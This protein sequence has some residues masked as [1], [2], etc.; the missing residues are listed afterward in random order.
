MFASL[1]YSHRLFEKA[2]FILL[3]SSVFCCESARSQ[4]NHS[5][6]GGTGP[7][8]ES[9][10]RARADAL[11]AQMTP[12]EKIGQMTQ[13]F[14]LGNPDAALEARIKNGEI[15]AGLFVIDPA[16]NNRIQRMAVEESRLHI[17]IL[18]GFDVIHGFKT[19]FPVPIAMAASWDREIVERAQTVAA[20][21]AYTTGIRWTFA[22]MVDIGRDPR[23]GRI[24]EGAGEDPFL[25]SAMA[26]AQVHGFQGDYL[27]APDHLVATVKHFA[28]YG[29]AEGGRDYDAAEIS[30]S[31][32]RNV[33]FPP[34]KNA[35]DA[36]AGVVMS[37]YMDLNGV[38]AS[39][40]R[41]LLHDVLR[42]EW[43]FRGFVVSDSDAVK[44]LKT[45]GFAV[46][47][48]DAALR[49]AKAG[50]NM[51][52]SLRG[53]A[54]SSSL[55]NLYADKRLSDAELDEAVRPILE[56]KIRLGLFENPYVD[57]AGMQANLQT[58]QN[59][60]LARIAAERSAVLLRNQGELLPLKDSYKKIAVIGSLADSK[61]DV[62]GPWA[63]ASDKKD[64][65]TVLE[66][67][68]QG[69]P[70][71]VS[72][73]YAGGVQVSR[74]FPLGHD[75]YRGTRPPVWTE[76]QAKQEYARAVSLA[77]DSDL[78]IV[79]LGE[80]QDMGGEE[81]SS[82]TLRLPGR[83]EE[84]LKDV[85]AT[86]KPVVLLLMSARPLDLRWAVA[87]VAAILDIWYPGT[88]GGTAVANL[89]FGRSVPGGK[90]PFTWVRDAGQV[91]T[92]YAHYS[93]HEP[94][95]QGARYWN[96]ES[97]PLFPFGFGLSYTSFQISDLSLSQSSLS[98]NDPLEVSVNVRNSGT[99]RG[100]EV[101]QI[102]IHQ[103]SGT[104]SRPVRELKGFKRI[105]LAPG[106]IQ[107]VRFTL[108]AQDRTYWS[109]AT[110][111][112]VQDTAG[113]DVWVGDDSA[114]T[115]H[116]AFSVTH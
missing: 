6:A 14:I 40:N 29:A 57:E 112:W 41:W 26:V 53:S 12:R 50:V 3:L 55:P 92:F 9:V 90:L 104:S 8:S 81:S 43:H 46:D 31:Q 82:S 116:G 84:L 70:S 110:R 109:A 51:E 63:F 17:P 83:Q 4:E 75:S 5:V 103:Q 35:I 100:D 80:N 25:G 108:T 59:Y 54:Y 88:Q 64:S 62:A 77:R 30:E 34:F 22:P 93:T 102:Y 20:K 28:G 15:G 106:E 13:I 101:V 99:T 96:E 11:L 33:Y 76:E 67:L 21:E 71:G 105:S 58:K 73:N 7:L 89:L 114:A 94:E 72:I 115:L 19:I 47:E 52:M 60:E 107:S 86:G 23:W 37:A 61:S 27:G 66:G 2:V 49:A 74:K 85:V 95:K 24:I 87:H 45:H 56:T 32:L 16:L 39:G 65:V 1:R 18:F 42:D 68:R 111:S 91:P 44:S 36:G 38:P 10:V 78:S 98:R 69:A 79:V 97:T 48:A 113:F